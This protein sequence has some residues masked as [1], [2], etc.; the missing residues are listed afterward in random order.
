MELITKEQ[1][2]QLLR[3]GK[4][5]A[6]RRDT[7]QFEIDWKPVVMLFIPYS[8]AAWLLGELNPNDPD[9]AFGLCDPGWGFAE[10]GTVRLSE[11]EHMVSPNGFRV[12]QNP[13]FVPRQSLGAYAEEARVSRGIVA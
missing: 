1:K 3:Q 12:E 7:G 10:L 4:F 13:D 2:E 5:N 9:Q 6:Y 8:N 11:L